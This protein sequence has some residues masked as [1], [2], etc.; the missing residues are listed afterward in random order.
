L[1]LPGA[2][3]SLQ[4]SATVT[5]QH[6]TKLGRWF[7]SIALTTAVAVG[8]TSIGCGYILY[9]ERR[10]NASGRVDAGTLVMDILWFIPGI[11]PGVVFLIVDF[12]SGAMYVGGGRRYAVNKTDHGKIAVRFEQTAQPARYQVRVVTASNRVVAMQTGTSDQTLV[13]DASSGEH[14]QLF[15]DVTTLPAI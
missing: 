14:E 11:I 4:F 15:V 3:C 12:S 2:V 7:R 6:S 13:L 5:Q 1:G 8:S 10:G 9:P